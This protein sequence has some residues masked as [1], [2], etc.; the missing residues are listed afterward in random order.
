MNVAKTILNVLLVF[1]VLI[2]LFFAALV[3]YALMR[4]EEPEIEQPPEIVAYSEEDLHSW[5]DEAWRQGATEVSRNYALEGLSSEELFSRLDEYTGYLYANNPR[6]WYTVSGNNYAS[7]TYEEYIS[8]KL[9]ISYAH[10]VDAYDALPHC[11]TIAQALESQRA[12]LASGAGKYVFLVKNG[13]SAEDVATVAQELI[14]NSTELA[15]ESA[16]YSYYFITGELDDYDYVEITPNYHVD[17]EALQTASREMRDALDAMA[18]ELR[19]RNI[20]DTQEL[21][22]AAAQAIVDRAGYDDDTLAATYTEELSDEQKILRSGYGAVVAGKSVCSGYA[23]A[24]KS[25]CD[26]LGLD[27]WVVDGHCYGSAHAW[28]LIRL[29]GENRYVDCTFADTAFNDSY[30]LMTEQELKNRGYFFPIEQPSPW[31]A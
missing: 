10:A 13:W 8:L 21:Y 7:T 23:M 11:E 25:L 19:A 22:R 16:T 15:A 3:V 6:Y 30:L 12:A 29:E 28:N 14:L 9:S 26:R 31:A 20:T 1:L 4:E 5:V 27:C 2:G 17:E 24:Y 18:G